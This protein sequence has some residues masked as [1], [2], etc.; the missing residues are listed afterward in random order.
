[1]RSG[2][3]KDAA[4]QSSVRADPKFIKLSAAF[5][6]DVYLLLLPYIWHQE[7]RSDK[8]FDQKIVY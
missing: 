6:D 7:K 1:M 4:Q 3:G 8:M 5:Q 2:K